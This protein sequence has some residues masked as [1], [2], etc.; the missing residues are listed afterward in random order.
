MAQGVRN[1]ARQGRGSPSPPQHFGI[2]RMLRDVLVTSI[3]RGQ[4]PPALIGLIILA[5]VLK[6]P[7]SDVRALLFHMTDLMERHEIFGYALAAV[8]AA[9][10]FIHARMQRRW[11]GDELRRIS[12]ER[13]ELK[14]WILG[15]KRDTSSEVRS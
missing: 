10:W 4:F 7:A 9:G 12:S 11:I 2:A 3:N 1:T 15:T 14:A 8:C 13:A 5:V 6:M